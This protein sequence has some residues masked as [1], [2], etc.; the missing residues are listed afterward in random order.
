MAELILHYQPA[1]GGPRAI[2][3]AGGLVLDLGASGP[4]YVV[5]ELGPG[6]GLAQVEAVLHG[7]GAY[8]RRA[9]GGGRLCRVAHRDELEQ[10]HE[11]AEAA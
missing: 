7:E 10:K 4:A 5:A 9:R 11:L 2:V 8:L 1:R 6:E 3:I